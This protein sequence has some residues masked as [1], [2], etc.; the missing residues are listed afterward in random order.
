MTNLARKEKNGEIKLI[1]VN[2]MNLLERKSIELLD[3]SSKLLIHTILEK[4]NDNA[5]SSN[6]LYNDVKTSISNWELINK[7]YN[8]EKTNSYNMYKIIANRHINDIYISYEDLNI[9]KRN[10]IPTSYVIFLCISAIIA[11]ISVLLIILG[12]CFDFWIINIWINIFI[13]IGAIGMIATV[14]AAI[15]EWRKKLSEKTAREV[16]RRSPK[17]SK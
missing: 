7:A 11:T 14:I 6:K 17:K 9:L 2:V 1:R 12:A 3:D 5:V 4:A 13:A 8:K 15:Y 16:N 10:S